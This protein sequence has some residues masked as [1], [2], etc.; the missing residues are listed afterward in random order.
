M[1][2]RRMTR[3]TLIVDI[4]WALGTVT[5]TGDDELTSRCLAM[6]DDDKISSIDGLRV[7]STS[8]YMTY[9]RIYHIRNNHAIISDRSLEYMLGSG[10]YCPLITFWANCA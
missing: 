6:N 8:T 10:G 7:G 5:R 9:L 4:I 1:L 3:G 2:S